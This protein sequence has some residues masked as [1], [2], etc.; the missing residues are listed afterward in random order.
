MTPD[1]KR[2]CELGWRLIEFKVCY[3]MPERVH[4][5]RRDDYT[6]PDAEYDELECEYLRLCRKLGAINTVVHKQRPEFEDISYEFAMMEVDEG[7][8]SVQLVL[9]KLG[10]KK[11]CTDRMRAT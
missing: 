7:R 2:H 8:S 1:E 3:Y 10:S 6:I 5:S 9:S 4:R 11:T